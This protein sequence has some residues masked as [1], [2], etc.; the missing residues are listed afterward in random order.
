MRTLSVIF[1]A[2]LMALLSSCGKDDIDNPSAKEYD[3]GIII[4]IVDTKGNNVLET[5]KSTLFGNSTV[6]KY[7]T[8]HVT[9]QANYPLPD[10]EKYFY[11]LDNHRLESPIAALD[12][13]YYGLLDKGPLFALPLDVTNEKE[14]TLTLHWQNGV[15]DVLKFQ[16]KFTL[17]K[18]SKTGMSYAEEVSLGPCCFN[19]TSV[20]PVILNKDSK[21]KIYV[22]ELVK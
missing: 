3:N 10:K 16:F 6:V 2:G 19:G 17:H 4:R 15:E 22:F 21:S 13:S 12:C 11:F 7:N 9:P 20:T 14:Q 5:Q 8:W 1:I 18:E